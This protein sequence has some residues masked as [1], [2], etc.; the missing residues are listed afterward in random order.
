MYEI[1]LRLE[2]REMKFKATGTAR[3]RAKVV[4]EK[5]NSDGTKHEC[6]AGNACTVATTH[7]LTAKSKAPFVV[8][9]G[10]SAIFASDEEGYT[11]VQIFV[12]DF[13][14]NFRKMIA[15]E[16]PIEYRCF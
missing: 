1:R 2:R 8:F 7:T 5:N 14:G 6:S 9:I 11:G 12:R 3:V 13:V 16:H 15:S 10:P 4:S